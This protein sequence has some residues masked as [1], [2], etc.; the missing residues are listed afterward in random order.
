MRGGYKEKASDVRADRPVLNQLIEDLQEG[1]VIIAEHIDRISRLSL[2]EAE[3]L[4]G[5]IREKA[6][7]CPFPALST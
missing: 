7:S 2:A 6:R 4:V 3:K 5:C 1:D